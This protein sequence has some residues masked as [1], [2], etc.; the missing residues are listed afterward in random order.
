MRFDMK[1]LS[2]IRQNICDSYT[3]MHNTKYN[4]IEKF[5]KIRKLK[6]N[7][8]KIAYKNIV[9]NFLSYDILYDIYIL[10]KN[11]EFDDINFI[12]FSDGLRTSIRY[13]GKLSEEYFSVELKTNRSVFIENIIT[14]KSMTNIYNTYQFI[15]HAEFGNET[16]TDEMLNTFVYFLYSEIM[17]PFLESTFPTTKMI[18]EKHKS[19]KKIKKRKVL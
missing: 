15:D 4:L 18:I 19:L 11:S 2:E 3:I 9:T 17:V 5:C 16:D 8:N 12:T 14:I 6:R 1:Y 13:R 7:S 10:L